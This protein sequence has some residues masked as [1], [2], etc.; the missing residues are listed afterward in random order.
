MAS[1][2][3]NNTLPKRL[4]ISAAVATT[5]LAG[6]GSRQAYAGSCTGTTGTYTCSGAAD[7]VNDVTQMLS[8]AFNPLTVTT[9]VGFGINTTSSNALTLFANDTSLSF[10]DLNTSL[11]TGFL[12]GVEVLNS[13]ID[14]TSITTTGTV[15]GVNDEGIF[16]HNTNSTTSLSINT[17]S[18]S[19]G[20][21]GIK[22]FNYG[23]GATSI[24]STG[25]VTGTNSYGI[26]A[27]S[28]GTDLTVNTNDV[29]GSVM[30]IRAENRGK[31][32]T[33]IT[34]TGML[35]GTNQNGIFASNYS[36]ATSLTINTAA[37]SG[38][39]T[40]VTARNLGLGATNITITGTVS[41]TTAITGSYSKGN[42][43]AAIDAR[44]ESSYT[45]DLIIHTVAVEGNNIGIRAVNSGTGM[46]SISSTGGILT[47]LDGIVAGSYANTTGLTINT[48]DVEGGTNGINARNYGKGAFSITTTGQV[49]GT[50]YNGI[51]ATTTSGSATIN[52]AAVTGGNNGIQAT[53]NGTGATS[54]TSTGT[55]TG[56]SNRGI[57]ARN[58]TSAGSLTI[59]AAAVTGGSYGI[60]A[61]NFGAGTTIITSTGTVTGTSNRG[62][63]ARNG[64]YA[65]SLTINAAAVTGGSYGIRATNYGTGATSITVSGAVTGG[66]K[67]A[68]IYSYN[69][70]YD[71]TITLNSGA[72]VSA[73]S[74]NAITL[75]SYYGTNSV[76]VNSGASV[77]GSVDLGG[78][79]TMTLNGGTLNVA[80]GFAL[81]VLG[82]LTN[83]NGI[84]NLRNGTTIG[85]PAN[86][87][88]NFTGGGQLLLNAN[89]AT[90][91]ADK[92]IIAGSVLAG[93]T[94]V[95]VNDVSTGPATGNA[96]TLVSV[97]GTTTAGD[98]TLAAPVVN[99][100][101]NYNTLA[102][103][104]QNWELQSVAAGSGAAVFTPVAGS[105]EALGQSLLTVANLPTLV[106][107]TYGRTGGINTG[108][109][110]GDETGVD[111]PVWFR[112]ASGYREI[113]SNSST[114]GASFDTRHWQ[115]QVGIDYPLVEN[116]NG[117]FVTGVNAGYNQAKTDITSTAGKSNLD[118]TGYSLGLSGTWYGVNDIYVD[119]QLQRSWYNTDLSAGGVGA[120]KVNGVDSDGYSASVEVGKDLALNERL[121]IIPQAQLTYA[122]VNTDNFTGT[123]AEIVKLSKGKSLRARFGAV[124]KQQFSQDGKTN[125][126]ILA[127]VTR[128]FE[129]ETQ[130]NVS[131]AQLSNAV[132]RWSG[133]LGG[134]LTHAWTKGSTSYELTGTVVGTTSLNNFGDSKAAQGQVNFRVN[135]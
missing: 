52:T 29:T 5:F 122:T 62:I 19:G 95:G 84:I 127:N 97:G 99:G 115:A 96:I 60:Y 51:K 27:K 66:A 7:S 61:R 31:G 41:T 110:S 4:A 116:A 38:L 131:G 55:V 40:G 128:E 74:G 23:K 17:A 79:G 54:I 89:F 106:E 93:G 123:N 12:R 108:A 121:R 50:A 85:A 120:G 102:L 24:T 87:S 15:T 109:S 28:Y 134:G 58:G 82:N 83:T 32:A 37:V 70:D 80:N 68:G 103:V 124:L 75:S 30:G 107:R 88:G 53:N 56:T 125:G 48:G 6:Y 81:S 73:A 94:S 126:F 42:A 112:L 1:R 34:S 91:T 129:D 36:T 78:T 92:L 8:A 21:Y 10:T 20:T 59:N 13:G 47:A 69:Y 33:S 49:T 26:L 135:F 46:T 14:A 39:D 67:G 45:T 71:N 18:V 57:D 117:R 90:D 114:T 25:T 63:Y 65:G 104:G 113:D 43:P 22:A 130:V 72:S 111:T 3:K 100:A 98:F 16:A 11:I 77:T 101:Y 86:V 2:N 118:T 105:F 132:D 44:N 133:Q 35:T 76:T 119:T 64:T 9:T